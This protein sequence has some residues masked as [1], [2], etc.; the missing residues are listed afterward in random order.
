MRQPFY[1]F[2]YKGFAFYFIY[3]LFYLQSWPSGLRRCVQVAV[4]SDAWVRT[5]QAANKKYL[6]IYAPAPPFL[7]Y[8]FFYLFLFIY[9][10]LFISFGHTM[11]ET[12]DPI[13]TLKLS[14]IGRA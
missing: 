6:F 2:I 3:F 5:P 4:S 8:L 12:P 11:V 13:R 9:F 7:F 10:Y 14:T 1:L